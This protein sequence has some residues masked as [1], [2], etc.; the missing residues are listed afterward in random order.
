MARTLSRDPLQLLRENDSRKHLYVLCFPFLV[1][2]S[3]MF[4]QNQH[5][6]SCFYFLVKSSKWRGPSLETLFNSCKRRFS[7]STVVVSASAASGGVPHAGHSI[8]TKR[9]PPSQDCRSR[10]R[11]A[12]HSL[13]A[14]ACSHCLHQDLFGRGDDTVGKPHRAQI[15][16]F[17][18]FEIII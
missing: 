3:F 13:I 8:R 2:F 5:I 17:E 1:C 15:S 7:L 12:V 16:Q 9:T 11:Q 10:S 18:L 6:C 14:R 4:K